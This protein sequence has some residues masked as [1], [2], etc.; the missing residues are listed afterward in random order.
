MSPL[1]A[2]KLFLASILK[3]SGIISSKL[4]KQGS[5]GF[6]ILMYHRIIPRSETE[7]VQAG[8]YVEPE[9][10]KKHL[11]FLKKY[12]RVV[13]LT[14]LISSKEKPV[15]TN[16]PFC[17]VTFDDGWQ[18]FYK[19]AFPV[20]KEYNFPAT[21]FLATDYIGTNDW[22]WTDRLAHILLEKLRTKKIRACSSENSTIEKLIKLNSSF[23]SRLETSIGI[24]KYL[25]IEDIEEILSELSELCDISSVPEE[26]AFL[27]WDEVREMGETGLISFGSHTAGHPILTTLK[28]DEIKEELI[29]SKEK[30]IAEGVVDDPALIPFCYPNGN[31]N[32]EIAGMVRDTGYYMA[33]TTK[34]GWNNPL[35]N[36]FVL[37]RVGIHQDVSSTVAM[38][39]GRLAGVF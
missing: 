14:D 30:L 28:P 3:S 15:S 21:V 5:G 39:G 4:K 7:G 16:K 29:R 1:I 36:R 22:F 33:V 2:I 34:N 20:L 24:L 32:K 25:R 19:Y 26:R 8:M 27:S 12:F 31:H 37:K 6:V 17:A 11:F 13:Y 38:F 18:D 23:E 35:S 9:T 10:F